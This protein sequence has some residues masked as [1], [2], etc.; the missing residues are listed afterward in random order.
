MCD[1]IQTKRE[2]KDLSLLITRKTLK[3]NDEGTETCSTV[4][5]LWTSFRVYSADAGLRYAGEIVCGIIWAISQGAEFKNFAERLIS[6]PQLILVSPFT[7][8][9]RLYWF[10][11][12]G[13]DNLL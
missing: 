12:Y 10:D 6:F 11:I 13:E 2:S 4:C 8:I 1:N 9:Y 3:L 7:C 5:K